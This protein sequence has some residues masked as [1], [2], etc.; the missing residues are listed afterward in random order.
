MQILINCLPQAGLWQVARASEAYVLSTLGR[1]FPTLD[2]YHQA[3]PGAMAA[4]GNPPQ[5]S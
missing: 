3:E 5:D 1:S 4:V 2:F